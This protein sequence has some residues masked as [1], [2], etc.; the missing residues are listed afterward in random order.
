LRWCV[1][2]NFVTRN[3]FVF[4]PAHRVELCYDLGDEGIMKVDCCQVEVL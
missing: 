1:G 2:W 3:L 4:S